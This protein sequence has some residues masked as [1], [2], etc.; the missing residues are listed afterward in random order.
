MEQ[1]ARDTETFK[2]RI[3]ADADIEIEKLK[4][5]L[6]ISATER[7]VMFAKL[8]EKRA[9]IIGELYGNRR[10]FKRPQELSY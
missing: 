8:H 1:L 10:N 4:S 5:S 6:Q 2:A 9:E 3:K 7:Q